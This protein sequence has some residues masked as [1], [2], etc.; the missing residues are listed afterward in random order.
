MPQWFIK[1]KFQL[2]YERKKNYAGAERLYEKALSI[3][4][5]YQPSIY[6]SGLVYYFRNDYE[7]AINKFKKSLILYPDH[8]GA[9]IAI[10]KSYFLTQRCKQGIPHLENFANSVPSN[11]ELHGLLGICYEKTGNLELAVRE[12]RYQLK[13]AP[14]TEMGIH[15]RKRLA[16]LK[17]ALKR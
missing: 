7:Q 5:E 1:T 4:P 3:D 15:A 10:G 11:P 2:K 13:V 17:P 9:H 12:Y 14:D 16:V 6:G 8:L